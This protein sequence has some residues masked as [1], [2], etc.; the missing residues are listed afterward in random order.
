MDFPNM[1]CGSNPSGFEEQWEDPGIASETE[2]GA[3]ISRAKFTKSRG[4]FKLEWNF[5][6]N[7]DYVIWTNFYKNTCKGKAEK[8]NWVHP[9]SGVTY[10]VRCVEFGASRSVNGFGW[11]MSIKLAEA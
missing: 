7:G 9:I 6:S 2:D 8:F 5:V 11:Q 10:V 1:S 3:Q 4:T